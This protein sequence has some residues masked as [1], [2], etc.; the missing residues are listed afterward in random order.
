MQVK[1]R[2][3][4]E[5]RRANSSVLGEMASGSILSLLRLARIFDE[6]HTFKQGHFS[7]RRGVG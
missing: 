5:H 4:T 2:M 3:G 7:D 1:G 6:P